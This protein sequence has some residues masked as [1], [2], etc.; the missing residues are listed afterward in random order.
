M[1]KFH[2]LKDRVLVKLDKPEEHVGR[3]IIPEA[4]REQHSVLLGTVVLLGSGPRD[5]KGNT[6]PWPYAVGDKVA[7]EQ[8]GGTE[9]VKDG[10]PHKL[11]RASE[12]AAVVHSL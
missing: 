3:I 10:V 6:L 7:V 8:Y 4:H 1:T 11:F 2:L 12:V 5:K 9:I